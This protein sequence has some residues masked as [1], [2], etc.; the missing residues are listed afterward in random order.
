M[1]FKLTVCLLA[2]AM[3]TFT[4]AASAA[5]WERAISLEQALK[6]ADTAAGFPKGRPS[7][8]DVVTAKLIRSKYFHVSNEGLSGALSDMESL[9]PSR[10]FW[11]IVYGRWPPRLDSD[12]VVFIDANTGKTIRVYRQK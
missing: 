2:I 1:Q 8:Y 4:L 5:E 11:L 9:S 10:V 3:G 7:D 6:A 12:L